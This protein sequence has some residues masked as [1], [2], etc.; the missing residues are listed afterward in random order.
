MLIGQGLSIF[1]IHGNRDFLLGSEFEKN[2]GLRIIDDM[3]V[4]KDSGISLMIAHGD[5]FCTEILNIKTLKKS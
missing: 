5:S 4:I 1:F 2:T 3:T